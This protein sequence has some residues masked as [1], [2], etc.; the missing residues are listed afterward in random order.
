MKS[1]AT[2][3]ENSDIEQK[4]APFLSANPEAKVIPTDDFPIIRTPWGDE[5]IILRVTDDVESLIR[6]LNNLR[7]PPRFSAVW[8]LDSYDLEFVFAPLPNNDPLLGRSFLFRFNGKQYKCEYA[9][10]TNAILQIS[11]SSRPVQPPSDTNHRNL[12]NIEPFLRHEKRRKESGTSSNYAI[13]SF[14]IRNLQCDEDDLVN[15]AKH[16]N[17]YM[18]YFDRRSPVILVHEAPIIQPTTEQPIQFPF[19]EFPHTLSG[20]QLDPYL[21]SLWESAANT[22]DIF[23][24]FLYNFQIVEY[25]AF[26]YLRDELSRNIRQI[27]GAPDLPSKL[28]HS[29]RQILDI[30]VEE[31]TPDEAKFN[32]VIQNYVDP[33]VI[34]N[35]VQPKAT[36]FSQSTEFDGGCIISPLIQQDWSYDIFK[37]TWIPKLPDTLRKLRNGVVHSR[38][39]RQAKCILPSSHN[40]QLLRP[41]AT[42]MSAIANQIIVHG[43]HK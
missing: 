11:S 21:L 14:Y 17:F 39:L 42:A 1:M 26:Y 5:T 28:D 3:H 13:T 31:K 27:L 25:A 32:A 33:S 36:F 22:T 6:S 35:E 19:G 40:N 12:G 23:R 10:T 7:L 18:R 24:R 15:L 30:M 34:W 9:Q 2:H 37:S 20:N 4:L 41:W 29:T 38:E 16:L 43:N 8:H